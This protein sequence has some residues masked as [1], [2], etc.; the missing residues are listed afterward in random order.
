MERI[1]V[2]GL[3]RM[4]RAIA[5]RFAEKG[6][7]V[8][9]WTRSGLGAERA[10]ALGIV[11]A[12][13]LAALTGASDLMILS[14][15]DDDAV[16]SVLD[17]LLDLPLSGKLIVETSTVSPD[18]VM[19]RAE[20]FAQAG[21]A[22]VDAPISGGPEMVAAGVCGV[23]VGGEPEAA[24]RFLSCVSA[25]SDKAGHVGPLGSGMVMKTIVNGM[26]QGYFATLTEM[27][28][29]AK[30]AELPMDMVLG[31]IANGPAGTPMLKARLPKIRGE[32]PG[33]GFPVEGG[34]KDNDVFLGLA[35]SKG[36]DAPTLRA[37]ATLWQQAIADH[38][39]EADIA[40]VIAHVYE[41]A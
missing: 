7:P 41:K 5:A 30:R 4:G 6:Y 13:D 9:G 10:E 19:R 27:M 17:A 15:Y 18:H 11:P 40:R 24:A 38:L 35:A 28:Q 21:A 20:R 2:I 3:G 34:A 26:L 1:G 12:D 31:I 36:V 32:D 33:V 8:T 39:A 14:L 22:I 23:F 16:A 25:I 37:A 29:I